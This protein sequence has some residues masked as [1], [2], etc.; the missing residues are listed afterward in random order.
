MAPRAGVLVVCSSV[1]LLLSVS[2]LWVGFIFLTSCRLALYLFIHVVED[3]ILC[4]VGS[5]LGLISVP[6]MTSL[7]G[8]SILIY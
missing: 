2:F 5:E 4:S 7:L 3:Q 6:E 1:S 8:I